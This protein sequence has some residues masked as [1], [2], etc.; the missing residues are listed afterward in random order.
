MKC[1][2]YSGMIID[3]YRKL[4]FVT[5]DS[6]FFSVY[7][8]IG[9]YMFREISPKLTINIHEYAHSFFVVDFKQMRYNGLYKRIYDL[10]LFGFAYFTCIGIRS[11]IF[12]V[13][14]INTNNC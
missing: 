11:P 4:G 7:V 2:V 14:M 12:P 6:F 13:K 1:I 8:R 9:Y 3:S 10:Y 5:G